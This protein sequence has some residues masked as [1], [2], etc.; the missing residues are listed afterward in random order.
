MQLCVH[1]LENYNPSWERLCFA[2]EG[3]SGLDLRAAISETLFLKAGERAVIPNGIQVEMKAP[4]T[5]FEIQIR[6]RS[7]L[8]AKK[9]LIVVNTPGT[10]DWGYRGEIMTILLNTGKEDIEIHPGDRIAQA[11]VCPIV[12][13]EIIEV[14]EVSQ[15][16]RGASK[17]GSSGL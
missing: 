5:N 7:G 15:T 13:P 12:R 3:D 6:P 8:A 9:G 11:V 4:T 14:D 1:Y 2:K 17:F 16:E 10:I